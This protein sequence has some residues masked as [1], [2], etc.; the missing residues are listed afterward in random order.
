MLLR[1]NFSTMTLD[2]NEEMIEKKKKGIS[3][4]G[5]AGDIL[6]FKKAVLVLSVFHIMTSRRKL[7]SAG[8]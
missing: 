5:T 6:K 4:E 3:Y 1:P 8:I 7:F 2:N